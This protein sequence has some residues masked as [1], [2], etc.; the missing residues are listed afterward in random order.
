VTFKRIELQRIGKLG[1]HE[2]RPCAISEFKAE[3]GPNGVGVVQECLCKAIFCRAAG[4]LEHELGFKYPGRVEEHLYGITFGLAPKSSSLLTA[5]VFPTGPIEPVENPGVKKL[6]TDFTVAASARE[7][8]ADIPN[9]KHTT[10]MLLSFMTY[11]F[12]L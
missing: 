2:V 8:A 9:I 11:P 3:A 10:T 7:K 4:V 5:G 12:A 1:Q 6:F